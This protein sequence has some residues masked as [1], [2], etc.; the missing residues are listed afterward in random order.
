MA[1]HLARSKNESGSQTGRR[2]GGGGLDR[3]G[4]KTLGRLRLRRPSSEFVLQLLNEDIIS[5][6]ID[7]PRSL[8]SPPPLAAAAAGLFLGSSLP[9]EMNGRR[10]AGDERDRKRINGGRCYLIPDGR[11][12]GQA[13]PPK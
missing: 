11:T 9:S 3:G 2:G 7:R 1:T 4:K 13:D 12:D 5:C 8:P 6:L 10:A